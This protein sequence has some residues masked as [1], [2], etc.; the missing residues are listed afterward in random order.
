MEKEDLLFLWKILSRSCCGR[1]STSPVRVTSRYKHTTATA[2]YALEVCL[3]NRAEAEAVGMSS[4]VPWNR[5][6]ERL[7]GQLHAVPIAFGGE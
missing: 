4:C 5:V 1:A 3:L 6:E 7:T 2:M